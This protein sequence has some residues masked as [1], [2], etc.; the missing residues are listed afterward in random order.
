MVLD[1]A[2]IQNL[3]TIFMVLVAMGTLALNYRHQVQLENEAKTAAANAAVKA[4]AV[5]A[6]STEVRSTLKEDYARVLAERD[7]LLERVQALEKELAEKN[8]TIAYMATQ[9]AKDIPKPE[10]GKA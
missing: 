3:T 10:G 8:S 7:R 6:A 5:Y 9:M 1:S 4:E 2:T